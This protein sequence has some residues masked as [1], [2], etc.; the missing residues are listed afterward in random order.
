MDD[1][2]DC[3]ETDSSMLGEETPLRKRKGTFEK[4]YGKLGL[5]ILTTFACTLTNA[6]VIA[7][8]N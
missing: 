6:L 2:D 7:Y 3:C 1:W 8:I 4:E 5:S